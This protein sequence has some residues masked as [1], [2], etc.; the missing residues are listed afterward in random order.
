MGSTLISGSRVTE[1]A[2]LTA[3]CAVE[4]SVGLGPEGRGVLRGF[5][6]TG[7]REASLHQKAKPQHS[8]TQGQPNKNYEIIAL[9]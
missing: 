5:P 6:L 3:L 1:V 7:W 9:C 8:H 2:P 4:G